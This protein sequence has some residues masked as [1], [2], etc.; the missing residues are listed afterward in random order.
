MAAAHIIADTHRHGSGRDNTTYTVN[1]KK[2]R[3]VVIDGLLFA[4]CEQI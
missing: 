2:G 4:K 1:E 3:Q